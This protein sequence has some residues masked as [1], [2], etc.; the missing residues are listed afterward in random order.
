MSLI[1]QG[2]VKQRT[3]VKPNRSLSVKNFVELLPLF[4]PH[5]A[6]TWHVFSI[7][8]L[9]MYLSNR[10]TKISSMLM[11]IA[12]ECLLLTSLSFAAVSTQLAISCSSAI[13]E[14]SSKPARR[15]ANPAIITPRLILAKYRVDYLDIDGSYAVY[16]RST[17][18]RLGI[19]TVEHSPTS[20]YGHMPIEFLPGAQGKGYGTEAK[21][22]LIKLIFEN[23]DTPEIE[24]Y[25]KN[26][27]L[28]SINL[29]LKLGFK[30]ISPYE[31]DKLF[32]YYLLIKEDFETSNFE[33]LENE[34]IIEDHKFIERKR[35]HARSNEQFAAWNES[36]KVLLLE[37]KIQSISP[38][39][40]LA[41][42]K[43]LEDLEKGELYKYSQD[44]QDLTQLFMYL[45]H[46]TQKGYDGP[47][48]KPS[49]KLFS[50]LLAKIK[51]IIEYTKII[52]TGATD[53]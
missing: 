8:I 49:K 13:N 32:G 23:T 28:A 38:D 29:H 19:V 21:A 20:D 45:K 14:N 16:E 7:V 43:I 48:K 40:I 25:I 35:F 37:T 18:R 27:N 36:V 17:H 33:F 5:L 46:R 26:T 51:V 50:K 41:A 53:L 44:P 3:S 30:Y 9:T 2:R 4:L 12:F 52:D 1:Y 47:V 6:T 15:F 22:A 10:F 31:F 24:A 39:I 42:S 11:L 34:H